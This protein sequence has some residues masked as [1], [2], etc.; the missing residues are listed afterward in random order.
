MFVRIAP[1][2]L[3][4]MRTNTNC[5]VSC[6][7]FGKGCYWYVRVHYVPLERVATLSTRRM[8]WLAGTS[9]RAH[10]SERGKSQ[11]SQ[12]TVKQPLIDIDVAH[13]QLVKGA[14]KIS[15]IAA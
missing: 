1:T 8:L 6:V 15:Q 11:G 12:A 13:Q 9:T 10:S 3:S 4:G 7:G 14:P 5:Y 2:L